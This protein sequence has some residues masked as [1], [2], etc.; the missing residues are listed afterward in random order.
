MGKLNTLL[1]RKRVTRRDFLKWMSAV[2]AVTSLPGGNTAWGKKPYK[3]IV[4][5]RNGLVFDHEVKV[6]HST[7]GYNCGSRCHHK[8]HVKNGRLLRITS[9]G[10]IP[11]KDS[12][13]SDESVGE[14]GNPM[15]R[16]ACA[17]CYGGY[18][19]RLYQPDR[20]KYPMIQT[21][22]RGDIT[23]FKR[24][25][26]EEA[27]EYVAERTA[28]AI[29]RKEVLGYVPILQKLPWGIYGF[30]S[31]VN[32]HKPYICLHGNESSGFA[33]SAKFDALGANAYAN[34]MSDR[35]NS[36]LVITWGL[37]SSRTT[38]WNEHGHW[39]STKSREAGVANVVISPNHTDVAAILATGTTVTVD[40]NTVKIPGWIPIRPATDGALAVAMA[41]V[42][43]KRNLHDKVFLQDKCFGFFKGQKIISTAPGTNLCGQRYNTQFPPGFEEGHEFTDAAGKKFK[44]GEKYAGASFQVPQGE[45]F[46]EYLEAL[47]LAPDPRDKA[48][49]QGQNTQRWSTRKKGIPFVHYHDKAVDIAVYRG[50]IDF[51][52]RLTGVPSEI[53]EGLA[54]KYATVNAAFLEV[55]GGPQRAWNGYE[56]SMAT[57]AL[58]A[59][60][61]HTDKKG[62]GPGGFMLASQPEKMCATPL[63][64][65]MPGTGINDPETDNIIY[66]PM[67]S[68][69]HTVL[70]GKDYRDRES[71]I[72][73]TRIC[74]RGALD[75]TGREKLLEIDLFFIRNLNVL[76]TS[77]FVNKKIEAI[78]TLKD[79]IVVDQVMTASATYADI[80][81]PAATH[82]EVEG[83]G[84][85][86]ASACTF[87][88]EKA[89]DPLYDTMN[90]EE[91]V[92]LIKTKVTE[93]LKDGAKNTEK[94]PETTADG[95]TREQMTQ[96]L[97]TMG[98]PSE[99]YKKHVDPNAKEISFEA[100]KQQGFMDHPVPAEKSIVGFRDINVPGRLENTTGRINLYSPFWGQLRPSRRDAT[101]RL[102][103]GMRSA[104]VC[105]LPN[106]EG[107]ESF[108]KD[109]DVRKAFTGYRSPVSNRTY[110]LQY[111]TNKARNRAHTVF[112]SNPMIK[113]HF[114]QT[115]KMN[116]M[117]AAR[118][119]IQNGDIV[120]IY[121]DRGCIKVPAELSH[122]IVPGAISVEHGGWYRPH[123]SETVT[124]W[125]NDQE[126]D[127]YRQKTVPVDIGGTDNVLTYDFSM[128]EIYIST[129]I[130]AQ[131]GACEVS[132]TK[133]A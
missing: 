126:D 19:Q 81:L 112:D 39:F 103:S 1:N 124:I 90:D 62:G 110:T 128:K 48:S 32:E 67:G 54:V 29:K 46:Q 63:P 75:L 129:G 118:R 15:Q 72:R 87:M 6:F 53:I 10:D 83:I 16:R 76:Q 95:P 123:P 77:E 44:T 25:S 107:Y 9:S 78:K 7:G 11:R 111:I 85:S 61:G 4:S 108:F 109:N 91:L 127:K 82:F 40:G 92:A 21:K 33:T 20:L 132:K 117:D 120:Y 70:T 60:A 113:D 43:Y 31:I 119:G 56:W 2:V 59:M 45:S 51:A 30:P 65:I 93:K 27:I 122:Y 38:Y 36:D 57:I 121:N 86:I 12:A 69:A 130:N 94:P 125:M 68:W 49:K 58:A 115:V 17:R 131:G 8:L 74:T 101:G 116:P 71:L 99:F 79:F 13:A 34:S 35:F 3:D 47:E 14:I 64:Q 50:V 73:D 114:P 52:A 18:I 96:I 105:Y 102:L 55:G 104:G 106:I 97:F 5:V 80:V 133:P 84:I 89:L 37:D 66:I 22:S 26:W 24:I 41:Y 28:A 100:F 42:I 98:Q 23:G 88:M